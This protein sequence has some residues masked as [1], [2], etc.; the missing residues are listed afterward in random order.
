LRCNFIMVV[1]DKFNRISFFVDEGRTKAC[2]QVIWFGI[3]H[4]MRKV[5]SQIIS[6]LGPRP[7][8]WP[9]DWYHS[10]LVRRMDCPCCVLS[11]S[12][13]W[14]VELDSSY[15]RWR[16][17]IAWEQK[18]WFGISRFRREIP[19]QRDCLAGSQHVVTVTLTSFGTGGQYTGKTGGCFYSVRFT[20]GS[21]IQPDFIA[22]W[23]NGNQSLPTSD[24][25][26]HI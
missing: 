13:R 17:A 14:Q 5:P 24:L 25:E 7:S 26:F 21:T 12:G 10:M 6:S 3:P 11:T 22:R 20:V 16:S 19:Y 23:R 4:L 2:E 15:V 8:M 9:L 1:A 18:F